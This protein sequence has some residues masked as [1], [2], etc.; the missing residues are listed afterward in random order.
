MQLLDSL[1]DNNLIDFDELMVVAPVESVDN[2]WDDYPFLYEQEFME[3]CP[4]SPSS[5]ESS[6]E[7]YKPF[8][9]TYCSRSFARRHDLQRHTRIHTGIKPYICPSCQKSFARSDARRRHFFSDPMCR[10]H[11]QVIQFK[12][13]RRGKH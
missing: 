5:T 10:K 12:Q 6:Y 3:M 11:T 13:V 7:A 4:H 1:L 9:C 8:T 2:F